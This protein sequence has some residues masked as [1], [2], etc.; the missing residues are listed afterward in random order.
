MLYAAQE[1]ISSGNVGLADLLLLV[2]VI[3]VGVAAAIA[4]VGRSVVGGLALA[5]A[6]CWLAAQFVL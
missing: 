1:A 5:G 4:F 6:A 3:V 2:A